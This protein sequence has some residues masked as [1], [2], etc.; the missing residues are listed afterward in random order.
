[1]LASFLLQ[2]DSPAPQKPNFES[3]ILIT[4][5]SVLTAPYDPVTP[6][7]GLLRPSILTDIFPT[8]R[9]VSAAPSR[10]EPALIPLIAT[11]PLIVT[12]VDSRSLSYDPPIIIVLS[13]ISVTF[14]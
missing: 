12:D 6:I 14:P 4:T 11:F 2:I 10:T 5:S 9:G 7:E 1:L 8:L 3:L 13:A